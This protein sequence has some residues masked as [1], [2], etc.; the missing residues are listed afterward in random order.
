MVVGAVAIA[1]PDGGSAKDPLVASEAEAASDRATARARGS[2]GQS[3]ASGWREASSSAMA[4]LSMT[5]D[6]SGV[7]ITGTVR[8]GANSARSRGS[9]SL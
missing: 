7:R 3:P 4:R 2:E 5:T 1:A 8:A 9:S 6:P